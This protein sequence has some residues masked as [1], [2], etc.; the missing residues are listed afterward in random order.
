MP[1]GK[2]GAS[3]GIAKNRAPRTTPQKQGN[4]AA[5]RAQT[6]QK[7]TRHGA[8]SWPKT[9]R[10]NPVRKSF[11]TALAQPRPTPQ[12]QKAGPGQAS[13]LPKTEPPERSPKNRE[14][15]RHGARKRPKNG[16][17]TK[18]SRG[19][20]RGVRIRYEKALARLWPGPFP[21]HSARRLARGKPRHCQ[22]G[23][24]RTIPQKQGCKQWQMCH[25][26]L[27]L[28]VGQLCKL[29]QLFSN[30]TSSSGASPLL[31]RGR[32]IS[33]CPGGLLKSG[34]ILCSEL[35][36]FVFEKESS[37]EQAVQTEPAHLLEVNR[38][39]VAG[40]WLKLWQSAQRKL[41][42]EWIHRSTCQW[43]QATS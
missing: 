33:S 41:G 24:P 35:L 27:W 42:E 22:N 21:S 28:A 29:W 25:A 7:R 31:G 4:A 8:V 11:G 38:S 16:P 39:E 37:R 9:G 10:P 18:Q 14:T 13:E 19:R 12:C 5:R 26:T 34:Q 2:P 6:A 23:A 32:R 30:D 20:K 3:L 36:Q 43:L 1:E 40:R 17:E 15:Q